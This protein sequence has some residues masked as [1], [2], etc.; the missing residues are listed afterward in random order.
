MSDYNLMDVQSR[1]LEQNFVYYQRLWRTYPQLF[2]NVKGRLQQVNQELQNIKT[3]GSKIRAMAQAELNK[4]ISALQTVF[5]ISI[6]DAAIY[7]R[8]F[9]N[10]LINAINSCIGIKEVYERNV[11]LVQNTKGQKSLISFFPTY[12]RKQLQHE[13]TNEGRLSKKVIS[14]WVNSTNASIEE[15]I[16][17]I[18][19]K[20]L[21]NIVQ[22]ALIRMLSSQTNI[23]NKAIGQ[24]YRN[25]YQQLYNELNSFS[26]QQS[27]SP[28]A[29]EIYNIYHV[30][31]LKELILDKMI[32]PNSSPKI[33][34]NSKINKKLQA[35]IYARG[36]YT[37]EAIGTAVANIMLDGIRGGAVHTGDVRIEGN[38]H[39]HDTGMKAD[40]IITLNID[41]APVEEMIDHWND[42]SSAVSREKSVKKIQELYDKV[43]D[44]DAGFIIYAN[45]KN[46]T[47][48]NKFGGF[49]AGNA[50][51]MRNFEEVMQNVGWKSNF[52]TVVG[53]ILQIA[54]GAIGANVLS[55]TDMENLLARNVA[56]LLFDDVN[57]IGIENQS[58]TNALHVMNLNGIY[59][60]ISL[61]LF[62]L[63]DAIDEANESTARNLVRIKITDESILFKT[64][65]EQRKWEKQNNA[66]P[67]DAWVY[68]RTVALNSTKVQAH[69]LKNFQELI[70]TYITHF[71][72]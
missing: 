9:Y 27:I 19:D 40:Y 20:E 71:E 70:Q 13:F 61:I 59:I 23:E 22:D 37:L 43:K 33:R 45:A 44:I 30:D 52:N 6:P 18:L 58:G 72:K 69:F 42:E 1:A 64:A 66:S 51:S 28:L 48:N 56:Y 39:G 15:V 54:D 62:S 55:R 10:H 21:P 8:E 38:L 31:E 29:R 36:G 68:Q 63:A 41:T 2:Q 32:Q 16:R 65:A 4:E 46:Y 50:L 26:Q 60:P 53:A 25:A 5:H 7:D 3:D 67:Y 24:E 14:Q 35:D 57:Q 49:S 47:Y 11:L 17:D 12:L 34:A